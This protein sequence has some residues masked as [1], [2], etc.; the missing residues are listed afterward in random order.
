MTWRQA[1]RFCALWA[2]ALSFPAAAMPSPPRHIVSLNTCADGYLMALA[3]PGQIA[4]LT[5]FARD[6]ALSPQPALASRLPMTAGSVE[7]G[8][9]LD[10]DLGSASP[11]R[12][13]N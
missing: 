6:P 4:A 2:M 10:P 13:A 9:A 11:F 1:K 5:R 12:P 7:A 8:L 3:D